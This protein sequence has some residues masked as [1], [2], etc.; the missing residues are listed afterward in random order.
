VIEGSIRAAWRQRARGQQRRILLPESDDIRVMQAAIQA[1]DE[2][3]CQPLLLGDPEKVRSRAAE[4][5]LTL[6]GSIE[7]LP[8]RDHPRFGELC[9]QYAALRSSG[10]KV[11][12][13]ASAARLLGN[14]LF[15]SAMLLRE[16][17]VDG[18]VAGANNTTADVARAAKFIVGTPAGVQDVSS[19]FIMCCRDKRFGHDGH[20]VFADAGV[21]VDPTPEQL[22]EIAI[23][24]AAT[25]RTLLGCEPRI[26]LLSFSTHGSASHARVSKVRDAMAV[27]K[28]RAPDLLADGELQVDAALVPEVASKKAP[29]SPLGGNANVLIFPDLNAGNIAYKLVER[30]A[31]ADAIGPLLQGLRKPMCDLSRGAKVDDILDVMAVACITPHA[32]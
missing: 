6:P 10:D 22:A 9:L 25:A 30:L 5:K 17:I 14:P 24:S 1:A 7:I 16:G 3:F 12:T 8:Q 19:A 11:T 2:G 13:P 28:N 20:L 31:G 23:A 27:L 32:D 18:V 15:F 26:A 29:G 4:N 21:I